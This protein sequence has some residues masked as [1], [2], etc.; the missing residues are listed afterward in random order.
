MLLLAALSQICGKFVLDAEDN[1][2]CA[3]HLRQCSARHE[4][5]AARH[6]SAT[7]EVRGPAALSRDLRCFSGAFYTFGAGC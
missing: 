2:Q 1:E 4:R 6:A 7:I 5:V 3:E